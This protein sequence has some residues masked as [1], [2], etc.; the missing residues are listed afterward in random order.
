VRDGSAVTAAEPVVREPD[1]FRRHRWSPIVRYRVLPW[2]G[3]VVLVYAAARAVTTVIVLLLASVQGAN[4]W[5]AAHPGYFEY[6]NLWDARWYEIISY[7]GYPSRLPLTDD[8]HVGENAWAFMPVFPVLVRVVTFAGLPWNAASVVVAL[9]AGLGAALVFHRLMSRFLAP[10]QAMFAVVLFSVAPVSP[11]MQFGY[12][13][14]LGF[15]C[16]AAA[17]LLL[18]DRRYGWLVP[19]VAAWSFTRPGAL[20]FALTLGLHWLVRWWRRGSDPFPL[21]ERVLAASVALFAVVAGLAWAGIAWAATGVPSAYTDTELAWRSAYIGYQALVP[22]TPWFLAGDWWLDQPLGTISVIALVAAFALA[23]WSPWVRRLG[24]DI[25]LWL[26]S[27]AL[28]LL[29]VFFPQSSSFR[30]LAPMFPIVGALAVPRSRVWRWSLV[31]LSVALKV[32][33]LL[34]AWGI[35]GRD[36]TP[37]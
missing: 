30:L 27:Y 18:V 36:W 3:R 32:G 10:D 37:P 6:A 2:W 23:L 26:G 5:T 7:Y 25:R 17:L 24:V 9:A 29:A 13:E 14:S 12:A 11:I 28:Y 20:A 16:L 35:D 1:P 22:F 21:R 19:L 8:G 33:W 15:L 31:V 4:P 34:I